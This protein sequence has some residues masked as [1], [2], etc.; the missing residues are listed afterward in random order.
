[1][2]L[3]CYGG[4]SSSFCSS[5]CMTKHIVGADAKKKQEKHA[6]IVGSRSLCVPLLP[7]PGA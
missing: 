3:F 5:L 2:Q 7:C 4:V 6:A 1:M